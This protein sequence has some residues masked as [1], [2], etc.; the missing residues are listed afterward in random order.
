MYS[1]AQRDDTTVVDEPLYAHHVT[2]TGVDRPYKAQLLAEQQSDGNAVVR[3]VIMGPCATKV[4]YCK[5]R[6]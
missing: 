1:F 5:V 3:D 4:L 2:A 6:L